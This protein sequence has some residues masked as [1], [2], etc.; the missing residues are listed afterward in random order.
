MKKF[1]VAAA[2]FEICVIICFTATVIA[3]PSVSIAFLAVLCLLFLFIPFL[4]WG[5]H[6]IVRH[7]RAADNRVKENRSVCYE[8][9]RLKS[10]LNRLSP[11]AEKKAAAAIDSL[12]EAIKYSDYDTWTDVSD[13]D[14]EIRKKAMLM[15]AEIDN[16]SDISSEDI[17]SL[18]S[19][20]DDVKALIK[21]RDIQIRLNK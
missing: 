6:Y 19:I 17:S 5:I 20:S 3:L 10:K 14:D 16:L 13:I 11:E 18:E 7:E 8:F 4:I 21:D 9:E 15:S 2:V 12:L 1:I